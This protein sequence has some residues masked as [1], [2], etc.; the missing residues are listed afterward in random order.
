MKQNPSN[1]CNDIPLF[2]SSS[3]P[4]ISASY[5]LED[6]LTIQRPPCESISFNWSDFPI[7][8]QHSYCQIPSQHLALN[9]SC[10]YP[11]EIIMPTSSSSDLSTSS[12]D[13]NFST[14]PTNS[15]RVSFS[16]SLEV[17]T[18]SIVLG[19]HP[20][21]RSLPVEL[22]W[23]YADTEFVDIDSHE[24]NKMYYGPVR[25]RSYLERKSLLESFSLGDEVRC[26]IQSKLRKSAPTS[27]DLSGMA[28]TS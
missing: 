2:E 17:R 10:Q 28:T 27:A 11:P 25:R 8:Q 4:P 15:K 9:K 24:L 16:T 13:T 1:C 6:H 26:Q 7:I 20:C 18:H 5:G 21:C 14:I 19:D 22:G 23:D 3:T 12:T